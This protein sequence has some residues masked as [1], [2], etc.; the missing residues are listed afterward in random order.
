MEG[1]KT[2]QEA[3][4]KTNLA[5]KCVTIKTKQQQTIPENTIDFN[6]LIRTSGKISHQPHSSVLTNNNFFFRCELQ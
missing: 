1:Y 4:K 2:L 3:I 6:D 5:I